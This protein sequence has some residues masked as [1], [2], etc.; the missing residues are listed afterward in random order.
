[1]D[2]TL[3]G[4]HDAGAFWPLNLFQN[5]W[6][7]C[8]LGK[9]LAFTASVLRLLPQHDRSFFKVSSAPAGLLPI[10][11][12]QAP[13]RRKEQVVSAKHPAYRTSRP[14]DL[15]AIWLLIESVRGM[16]HSSMDSMSR[17]LI[18]L[19]FN[20]SA[21]SETSGWKIELQAAAHD[22]MLVRAWWHCDG[23]SGGCMVL[24]SDSL[25]SRRSEFRA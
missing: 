16:N 14:N 19:M 11:L 21:V 6:G 22:A 5:S 10:S 25:V 3:P 8:G 20:I 2:V 23:D 13:S 7:C 15:W 12:S 24:D 4:S 9:V 17:F 1:M 18:L